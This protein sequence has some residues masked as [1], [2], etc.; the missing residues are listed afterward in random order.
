MLLSSLRRTEAALDLSS[1]STP[2]MTRKSSIKP[3]KESV[4]YFPHSH[5]TCY[6]TVIYY[7]IFH[8]ENM[9]VSVRSGKLF[10]NFFGGQMPEVT[11]P[12]E[13]SAGLISIHHQSCG[14]SYNK[15]TPRLPQQYSRFSSH[16]SYSRFICTYPQV[17]VVSCLCVYV[18]L[19]Y[20]NTVKFVLKSIISNTFTATL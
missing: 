5:S 4:G 11:E 14:S 2:N 3:W 15:I 10:I 6:T 1:T 7:V 9:N 18:P 16:L 12:S 13:P 19:V 20:I 8:I 17:T